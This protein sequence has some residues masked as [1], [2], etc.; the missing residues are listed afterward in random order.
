MVEFSRCVEKVDKIFRLIPVNRA[1][2]HFPAAADERRCEFARSA[3]EFP[4]PSANSHL[5]V[6]Q[7]AAGEGRGRH[8][9][10]G[11]PAAPFLVRQERKVEEERR[12][13]ADQDD[14]LFVDH[15]RSETHP[16][17]RETHPIQRETHPIQRE[18]HPLQRETHPIQCETNP[19]ISLRF[20]GPPVPITARMHSTTQSETHPKHYETHSLNH[21]THP[22]HYETHSKHYET[23]SKHYETHSLNH[24]THPLHHATHPIHCETH[25]IYC[26]THP[27]H[28]Y[29]PGKVEFT[30]TMG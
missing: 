23:H 14:V 2:Y 24:E 7:G 26:E 1:C 15:L 9:G 18:T 25:P 19:T 13:R 22:K 10:Q 11:S 28:H 29:D 6:R 21:E 16:I 17:Q 4:A 5:E 3:P 20:T 8:R 12:H 30:L 27:I